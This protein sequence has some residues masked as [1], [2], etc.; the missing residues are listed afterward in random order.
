MRLAA[1]ILLGLVLS[2]SSWT[3]RAQE[4]ID[5]SKITCDQWM[6]YKITDP[7]D[8]AMWL[9]GFYHSKRND[10]IIEVQEFQ[11]NIR[12]LEDYCIS[13]PE[14]RIMQVVEEWFKVAKKTK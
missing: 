11:A 5:I 1:I 6:G 7:H 14:R 2:S 10:T 13:H 3:V 4:T 9:N 12:K 8:I